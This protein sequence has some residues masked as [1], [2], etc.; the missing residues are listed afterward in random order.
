MHKLERDYEGDKLTLETGKV[1]RR[2][3]GAVWIQHGDNIVL[4]TCVIA[5]TV[6]SDLNF[7]PLTVN[8]TEKAYAAGKIPGGFFKRE[9]RPRDWEILTGRLVDRPLRPL[10]PKGFRNRVQ[11]TVSVLSADGENDPEVL[12][13]IGASAALSI[14]PS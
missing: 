5:P 12:S 2:S 14:A 4:A 6:K 1:A 10:F 11:V 9:G 13:I 8:Y 3:S 7:V